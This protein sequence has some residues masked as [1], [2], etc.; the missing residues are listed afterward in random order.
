V[1]GVLLILGV[2]L[3]VADQ[4]ASAVAEDQ[5][6]SRIADE[7]AARQVSYAALDVGVTGTPFLTQVARSR[8]ESITI[9]MTGV[10][11]RSGDVE[12]TLPAL[13]LVATDV[14]ADALAV[15]RGDASVTADLV[16]GNAVVS[17]AGLSGLV[18]L[19]GYFVRDIA[20]TERGGA[21]YASGT[22][23]VAG[24]NL[25][26]EVGAEVALRDGQ[27]ELRFRDVAASG[28]NVPDI[29]L[30]AVDALVNAAIVAN[31]PPLPY[32]ITLDALAVTPDGLAISASGREVSLV[33][34]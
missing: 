16:V 4:V 9:D 32:D 20:F 34:G 25:P 10:R 12:A 24:I 6:R 7:L 33:T 3:A 31:M 29:A 27:I 19:S 28:M 14:R 13:D 18:D 17:Y 11:L 5:L 1:L 30:P 23:S 15:A 22:V 2:M 26:I 8:Y 21:L